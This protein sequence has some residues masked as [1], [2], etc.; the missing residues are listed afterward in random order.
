MHLR[1]WLVAHNISYSAF[2]R[3]L[4]AKLKS[5]KVRPETVRR[6]CLPENHRDHRATTRL[7]RVAIHALTGGAV[8]PNDWDGIGAAGV[9][10]PGGAAAG[11]SPAAAPARGRGSAGRPA[12]VLRAAARR[13]AAT[14][15]KRRL[16]LEGR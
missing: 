11:H 4:G 1:D 12:T 15:K 14:R 7:V 16:A 3:Q 9:A 6:Y 5:R 8:T 2:A 10:T 13:A